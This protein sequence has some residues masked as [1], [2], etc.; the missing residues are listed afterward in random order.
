MRPGGRESDNSSVS[1]QRQNT[2]LRSC[3]MSTVSTDAARCMTGGIAMWL[4]VLMDSPRQARR[5]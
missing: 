5:M 3:T 1:R 2:I 4:R